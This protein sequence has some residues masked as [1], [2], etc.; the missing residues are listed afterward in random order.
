M[1]SIP[2]TRSTSSDRRGDSRRPGKTRPQR[3]EVSVAGHL[4]EGMTPLATGVEVTEV[5]V[6]ITR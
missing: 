2:I 3:A 5:P 4:D 6:S 1:S